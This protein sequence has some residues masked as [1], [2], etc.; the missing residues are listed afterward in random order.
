MHSLTF[1]LP[2]KAHFSSTC[3]LFHSPDGSPIIAGVWNP[4]CETARPWKV[5]IGFPVKPLVE[6]NGKTKVIIDK[7]VILKEMERLGKGLVL[8]VEKRS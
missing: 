3:L 2:Q 4:T 6:E 7:E 8:K 1:C 5:G